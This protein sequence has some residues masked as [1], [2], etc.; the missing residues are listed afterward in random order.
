MPSYSIIVPSFNQE[1][2][3]SETLQK[4][5]ELKSRASEQGI[6]VQ[7]ILVDNCSSQGTMKII[8]QFSEKIDNLIVEKDNGQYDAINKGLNVAAGDYWSWLNTDDLPDLNGFLKINE[9]LTKHPETDYIY[10]DVG[11][12]D[13]NSNYYKT[14][15]SNSLS[16]ENL[17]N[18][19]PSIS[20]PGSFFKK[21]FTDKI[22]KLSSYHFAFDYEYV[23]R[24]IKN[25]A[26]ITKL[27]ENVAYFRY[28]KNSKSGSKNYRF[29]E[30]QWEIS[31]LYGRRFFSLLTFMLLIRVWKRKL[32]N[33]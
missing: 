24:C 15:R 3:I 2:Y 23:L 33:A 11:Y 6:G 4:L 28:Y 19:D 22:G 9:Y 7:L 25:G 18:K 13:E 20:Q 27:S 21:T 12:I 29:L 30:E 14:Y 1:K 17:V 26:L 32:F 31:K 8:E 16:M 10:G 5:C